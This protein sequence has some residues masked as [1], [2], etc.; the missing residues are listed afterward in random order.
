MGSSKKHKEKD[1][2][3]DREKRRDRERKHRERDSN[4]D[5]DKDSDKERRRREERAKEKRSH[6]AEDDERV[7]KKKAKREEYDDL[8]EYAVEE[9]T[10]D[11]HSNDNDIS[12]NHQEGGEISLSIEETNKL[13]IKLGLKPLEIPDSSADT[14]GKTTSSKEDVHV[15]A[16]NMSDQKEAE[17]FKRK[18]EEM[19]EKRRINKKLGKV[20]SLG[21]AD[22]DD[23]DSAASWVAKSG[24]KENEKSLAEKRA[25]LLAEMDE[26]FGISD[27]VEEE[28]GSLTTPTRQ[29]YSSRDLRG[30]KVEHSQEHFTEGS[31]MIMT[32]KDASVLDDDVEET[33]INVNI[34]DK[35]KGNKNVELRKKKPDYRPYDEPEMDEYGMVKARGVLDKYDE[36]IEGEQEQSFVLGSEGTYDT[37]KE[38]EVKK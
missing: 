34:V 23:D 11:D 32:L 36:E 17:N 27:L 31:S 33:L 15:P 38:D 6:P 37:S 10:R 26:E 25:K 24:K 35:E 12:Q 7:E 9:S 29:V 2:D 30:L 5:R 18:L 22:S 20:K 1:K 21:A 28:F 3:R 16:A 14:E 8:Y 19:R 4:K 13:R